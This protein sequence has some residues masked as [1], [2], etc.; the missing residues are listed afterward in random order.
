MLLY[1]KDTV[2]TGSQA[3]ATIAFYAGGQLRIA[4]DSVVVIEAPL[5]LPDRVPAPG[6]AAAPGVARVERG[7]VR[8]VVKAGSQPL[9]LLTA[10]GETTVIQATKGTVRFRAVS[11]D[12]GRLSLAL[13]QG[14]AEVQ[15]A[16]TRRRLSAGQL[17]HVARGKISQPLTLLDYPELLAPAVDAHLGGSGPVQLQWKAVEG[18]VKY[19]V[20]VSTALR[21]DPLNVDVRVAGAAMLLPSL[22]AKTYAWRV[23]S[24]DQSGNEGEFGFARRFHIRAASAAPAAPM[25]PANK[26]NGAPKQQAAA[27]RPRPTPSGDGQ[28]LRPVHNARLGPGRNEVSFVW[29]SRAASFELVIAKS[30]DLTRRVARRVKTASTRLVVGG[31]DPA[32]YYW[33]VYALEASERK[34]L[35]V[36]A[37][38]LVLLKER[39]PELDVPKSIG[40]K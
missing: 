12:K 6:D 21:F 27:R 17:V 38:R 9:R 25:P 4:A 10:N 13:M 31:L 40:W 23:S 26:A 5:S 15:T 2:K 11:A 14:Q 30:S 32:T 22:P 8:G 34:P 24:I 39:P 36:R 7:V 1:E 20:Q 37:R 35:F 29:R 33:G 19:H 18:A 16:R 28:M 3:T